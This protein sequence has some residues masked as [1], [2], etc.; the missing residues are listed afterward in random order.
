MDNAAT[1]P[2]TEQ[3]WTALRDALDSSWQGRAVLAQL[4]TD[5][6][7]GLHSLR[8][9]LADAPPPPVAAL[10]TWHGVDNLIRAA[11]TANA[12]RRPL[13]L[14]IGAGVAVLAVAAIAA[15][16]LSTG[17][18]KDPAASATNSRRS[19]SASAQ[20]QSMLPSSPATTAPA[21]TTPVGTGPVVGDIADPK[22]QDT[23][24]RRLENAS[25][26]RF[27]RGGFS[28]RVRAVMVHTVTVAGRSAPPGYH[29]LLF[30]T[31]LSNVQTDRPAPLPVAVG[32]GGSDEIDVA[33]TLVS[34]SSGDCDGSFH[35]LAAGGDDQCA[36]AVEQVG[37][38]SG[39][40]DKPIPAGASTYALLDT[41]ENI[42]DAVADSQVALYMSDDRGN[43]ITYARVPLA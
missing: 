27:T 16:A 20:P 19:A 42:P 32:A 35:G 11:E 21:S 13:G 4:R 1:A 39:L 2:D 33:R 7:G 23:A 14:L 10:V 36:M 8:A 17:G 43:T 25:W 9:L 31:E 41:M 26:V 3:L 34:D 38:G 24:S 5:R 30:L 37:W 15:V 40:P 6:A 12:R 29:T 18:S 28:Y 22:V